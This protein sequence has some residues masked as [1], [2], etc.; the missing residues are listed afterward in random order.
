MDFLLVNRQGEKGGLMEL[1]HFHEDEKTTKRY[2]AFLEAPREKDYTTSYTKDDDETEVHFIGGKAYKKTPLLSFENASS[3][4]WP[5]T[6]VAQG[7]AVFVGYNSGEIHEFHNGKFAKAS[8][9]RRCGDGNISDIAQF[10]DKIKSLVVWHGKVYDASAAGLFETASGECL[11][12]R[13]MA[14]AEIV[15]DKLCVVPHN[16]WRRKAPEQSGDLVDIISG[17]TLVENI[18]P[19]D[20]SG[21]ASGKHSIAGNKVFMYHGN[22]PCQR[23]TVR[24]LGSGKIVKEVDLLDSYGFIACNNQVYD[25][26]HM[27]YD[28]PWKL[29]KSDKNGKESG[30]VVFTAEGDLKEVIDTVATPDGILV[31]V[32][33]PEKY[34]RTEVIPINQ[35]TK[36]F[37]LAGRQKLMPL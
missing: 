10:Y 33:N 37:K 27:D 7:N 29:V 6:A 14:S 32:Y 21:G 11:D 8:V 23:I 3:G 4:L 19:S 2:K 9:R 22:H 31:F 24:E 15:E 34:G 5:C 36:G 16:S 28:E 35:N 12:D 26:R 18:E 1:A 13:Y 17:K 25:W 30:A 20:G